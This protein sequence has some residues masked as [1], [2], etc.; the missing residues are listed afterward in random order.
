MNFMS[1]S[2]FLATASPL[3]GRLAF[4]AVFATL[5]LWLLWIPTSR[6]VDSASADERSKE[7][8]PSVTFVRVAAIV[9]AGIQ[10]LLYLF[11]T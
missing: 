3:L 4:A 9:V 7:R 2:C 10:L 11:W 1:V 8:V 5:I 6:L